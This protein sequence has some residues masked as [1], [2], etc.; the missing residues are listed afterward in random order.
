MKSAWTK[1]REG[2][3][4]AQLTA[5]APLGLRNRSF[6]LTSS[7]APNP[8]EL[9]AKQIVLQIA[10]TDIRQLTDISTGDRISQF[11]CHVSKLLL[12]WSSG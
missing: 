9:H 2:G 4:S 11:S 5:S 7:Q 12:D 3:G 8:I 6:L 10:V 1:A